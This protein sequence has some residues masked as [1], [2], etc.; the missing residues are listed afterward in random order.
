MNNKFVTVCELIGAQW[1][2]QK[3]ETYGRL[4]ELFASGISR[5]NPK[6]MLILF[7][8]VSLCLW[9]EG[10]LLLRLALYHCIQS[11]DLGFTQLKLF[12]LISKK[13]GKNEISFSTRC[14]SS[15]HIRSSK[16]CVIFWMIL[17]AFQGIVLKIILIPALH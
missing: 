17:E 6:I 16:Y 1:E 9:H 2:D 7:E 15:A 4:N 14:F 3:D 8:A 13:K 5:P 10:A 12:S 11:T